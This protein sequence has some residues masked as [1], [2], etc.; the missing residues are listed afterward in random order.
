MQYKSKQFSSIKKFR[1]IV[2]RI[3]VGLLLLIL[4]LGILL[5]L[6]PVQTFVGGIVTKELRKSTQA[7]ISVEKVAISVFGG[8]KLRG[9]LIK[10]HHQDT[11]IYSK[12][13]Q[14]KV[15]S[16]GRAIKGDLIF[17][18]LTADNLTFYL[19]TYK[20]EKNSNINIFVEKLESDQPKSGK[21]FILTS[22]NLKVI[23]GR[24]K[25]EDKNKETPVSVDFTRL[26]AELNDFSING[27][28][29][30]ADSELFS[31]QYHT[32]VFVENLTGKIKYSDNQ[33]HILDLDA[34]TKEKTHLVGAIVLNYNRGDLSEFTDKVV[35]DVNFEKGSKLASND[36][37][38]F[39][40]ELVQNKIYDFS[41]KA[42]GTLNDF[43]AQDLFLS[44][45]KM[46]LSGDLNFKNITA[47]Q[48]RGFTISGDIAELN[49]SNK[50]LKELLPNVLGDK[51]PEQLDNLGNVILTGQMRLTKSDLDL[52]SNIVTQIGNLTTD[53]KMQNI[54]DS[55]N[56]S[57]QGDLT[58][59]NFDLGK[60]LNTKSVGKITAHLIANG[61]G[62]TQETVNTHIDGDISSFY[63]NGYTYRKI[64]VNG[65]LKQPYFQGEVHLDDDNVKL[66][67]DGLLDLTSKIKHYDFEAQVDYAD[68]N[69]LKLVERDSISI[70]KG[71]IKFK[72]QGNSLDDISGEL[73][74]ANASYQNQNDIYFFED[75][76]ITSVFDQDRVR[77]IAINSP[78]IIE[79]TVIGRFSYSELPK[80]FEN[81]LGSL[82][83]NY[84]PHS[85]KER[86]FL[87]FNF[88]IYNKIVEVFFPQISFGNN[89]SIRGN[90]NPDQEI[91]RV[92]FVTPTLEIGEST[93]HKIDF[94]I[95]N[96]NPLFNAYV[97]MDSIS[98]KHYKI[99]DF[100]MINVKHNDTLYFRTEFKGGSKEQ[101]FYN[102]NLY[103]TIDKEQNSIVG[104][105]KSELYFKD[106]LWYLNEE[107]SQDSRIVL[108]RSIND[109]TVD[110]F[111]LSHNNQFVQFGGIVRG[112]D[113]KDLDL[114][115]RDV[116]LSKI[117]PYIDKLS[118]EGILNGHVNLKQDK[119]IYKPVS[120]LE[121]EGF[122][123]ND[124]KLGDLSMDVQGDDTFRKF[125]VNMY[126]FDQDEDIFSVEGDIEIVGK[127]TMTELDIRMNSLDISPFSEFGGE[128]MTNIR[129]L[130]TGRTT[131]SGN[132]KNPEINGRIFLDK[133]GMKI[134]YLNT[135]FD[136]DDNSIVDLTE[137]QILLGHINLTDTKYRTEGSLNGVINHKLFSDWVLDLDLSSNR[138]LVLD[139]EDSD[140]TMYYGT[141]FIKGSASIQGPT[142][143][144]VISADV[145][146]EKG[147]HIYIP[148]GDSKSAG[149]AS[150]I[151]FLTPEEK[152]SNEI[153]IENRFVTTGLELKLNLNVTPDAAIDIIIDRDTGHAIRGGRGNG[154]L[155]LDINTLGRFTMNGIFTVEE[156]QYDFR[157]GGLI[158]KEFNV[159]RGG[160][161]TWSGNPL[162]ANLN[163]QGVYATEAN[164]A[165]LLDNPSF[166][167]KIPVNLIIDIKGTL[168]AFQEPD[169]DITFPSVSSVLQSE[170]QYKLSDADTRR[171]QA[172]ALLAT[173]NFLGSQG[174]GSGALA[175]SLTETASNIFNNLILDDNSVF[176]IG[177]D[178]TVANRDPNRTRDFDD[179][180][181]FNM[182]LTTEINEDITINGRLGVP[183]GGT[184]QSVV[185]GNVEIL[186][187]LNED[188]TLNARVFNREN[189]INYFG[190]G[191]G[192]TQGLGLTWEVDF[193]SF[194]ELTSK[195]FPKKRREEEALTP[196][197]LFDVDSDFNNEYLEFIKRRGK[198]RN[199]DSK[200]EEE[201]TIERVPDP[202]W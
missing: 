132:L 145:T 39:Y 83:T 124:I 81:A 148:V 154:V 146:S 35:M 156:G 173:R 110:N 60:M 163:I 77:M 131:V 48:E 49:T 72:G 31:F 107:D 53:L 29:I 115:F 188:R 13:I 44:D 94:Q 147:T 99:S 101:D 78:D 118:L 196:E 1:K 75:F 42:D 82:Y 126:L 61:K 17:G 89:T 151:K 33:I 160:T 41:V 88:S 6:P 10:D 34:K 21:P 108:N 113:Y 168:E 161:I 167:Q 195:I 198:Q 135:D 55:D 20:G 18:D 164:P 25:I 28:V 56:T 14:T 37:Y 74:F 142:S 95:D 51:L 121:V 50:S 91:F 71:N 38:F 201:P 134:A 47:V 90:I 84:S 123:I 24:F 11:L 92:N 104:F 63:F 3:F 64:L 127:N 155:E 45:S 117:T 186:I 192:Y 86:Q 36:I 69:K 15:L 79:G 16:V 137:K 97:Q 58:T 32:G 40:P 162:L 103:Y 65:E 143:G 105:Q 116:D 98:N 177:V 30:T 12:N 182:S 152:Y 194:S 100:G 4:L 66:S 180:D 141:A 189:D 68:L 96:K 165:V 22:D 87:R 85:I 190:E 136:F 111:R 106:Y 199:K 70:L 159:K 150:Y 171:T 80:I 57:Y 119:N 183:V 122:A 125:G 166:N 197:T 153:N 27:D 7:D 46:I 187:R 54:S 191:I 157:Y 133:A 185:V 2:I 128:V 149:E 175:G 200:E 120:S 138:L 184:Q 23:N 59:Q 62:F 43:L 8:V 52:K 179:S 181:R 193:D 9:V 26:N 93:V 129:G 140:D 112:T 172:F 202:Y 76:N 158:K 174:M 67:F 169:F 5:T 19:T 102:L 144:L 176:Q 109:F 73:N 130:A 178:Y 114:N 170:I 139:T